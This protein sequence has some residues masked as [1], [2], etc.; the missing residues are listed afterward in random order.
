MWS[1]PS[2]E[3]QA[4]VAKG[5]ILNLMYSLLGS[6][7]VRGSNVVEIVMPC[8]RALGGRNARNSRA[9][10]DLV[11]KGLNFV[12]TSVINRDIILTG[13]MGGARRTFNCA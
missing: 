9:A 3:A 8:E 5:D 11:E 6:V 10:L 7:E 2:S 1:T 4:G 13:C 12:F